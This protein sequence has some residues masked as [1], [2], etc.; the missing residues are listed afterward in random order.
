M[1]AL[2]ECPRIE[3]ISSNQGWRI[4][5]ILNELIAVSGA[6]SAL[7]VRTEGALIAMA[8]NIRASQA[9]NLG[10]FSALIYAASQ[11]A[12]LSIGT[13]LAYVHQRGVKKDCLILKV[14]DQMGLVIAFDPAVGLGSI[15]YHARLSAS[16]L[17]KM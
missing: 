17:L 12:T 9:E 10:M 5:G 3:T 6:E 15:L 8:G 13:S 4:S 1:V 11:S 16:A 14:N 2:S 7:V